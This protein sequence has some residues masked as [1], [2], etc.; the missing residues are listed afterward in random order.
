M[1]ELST[2]TL[3]RRAVKAKVQ[4]WEAIR[5]LEKRVAP[6]GDWSDKANVLAHDFIADL[7]DGINKDLKTACITST[8]LKSFLNYVE[9]K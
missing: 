4:Y 5:A 3:L 7:A 8:E 9:K 6:K 2:L 1:K